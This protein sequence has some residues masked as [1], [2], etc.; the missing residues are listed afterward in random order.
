MFFALLILIAESSSDCPKYK[1][2]SDSQVFTNTTCVYYK[3]SGSTDYYYT[4]KCPSD[5]PNTYCNITVGANST[6]VP[7]QVPLRLPGEECDDSHPCHEGSICENRKCNA[8]LVLNNCSSNYDCN[9]GLYC[10]PSKICAEQNLTMACSDDFMCPNNYACNNTVGLMGNCVEYFSIEDYGY[11]ATCE[12]N[13]SLLCNTG[14]CVLHKGLNRCTGPVINRKAPPYVCDTTCKSKPDEKLGDIYFY[15]S[16]SCGYNSEQGKVCSLF[17][18]DDK[19]NKF[20]RLYKEWYKGDEIKKCHTMGRFSLQCIKQH[21]NNYDE[22]MYRYYRF[23]NYSSLYYAED[24]IKKVYLPE[25]YHFDDVY[26]SSL[27]L[28]ASLSLLILA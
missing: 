12:K 5:G 22:F 11:V 14:V 21:S 13:E 3:N 15:G 8:S 6:C 7:P 28:I 4:H 19:A 10:A 27:S 24:C 1:C 9:V 18:Q 23:N 26:D 17:N 16:C 25:Y 2:K 20:F